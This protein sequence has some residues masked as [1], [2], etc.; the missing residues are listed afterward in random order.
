MFI[1]NLLTLAVSLGFVT[2]T[3]AYAEIRRDIAIEEIPANVSNRVQLELNVADGRD[4]VRIGDSIAFCFSANSLGYISLW[5]VGT[6]GKV[7]KLFPYPN[8]ATVRAVKPGQRECVGNQRY[9][10]IGP[11]GTENVVLLWTQHP[12]AQ[13]EAAGFND[14][15]TFAER[16]AR[17]T[18]DIVNVG[19]GND[20]F[21]AWST[22]NVAFEILDE[23]GQSDDGADTTTDINGIIQT[24]VNFN[25]V[26]VIA[27]GS[28]VGELK[29][30]N[31]DARRF[32]QIAKASFNIPNANIRVV[33]N[34]KRA[35]FES[36]F[37]WVG[38]KASKNDLVLFYYSGHG[39]SIPDDNGDEHDGRDEAIVPYDLADSANW[40]DATR[41]IRDDQ[42]KVW[43]NDISA[44]AVISFFDSC[45]SGGMYK[46]HSQ[47]GLLNGRPKFFSGGKIA[48]KLPQY[49]GKS[50]N[51]DFTRETSIVNDLENAPHSQ[52]KYAMIA[53]S[54][55]AQYAIEV[56]GQG[57]MFT[58]GL[59]DTLKKHSNSRS[60]A[61]MFEPLTRNVMRMSGGRQQ[62]STTD[63]DDLLKDL[64]F[65]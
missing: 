31:D 65:Q 6:S 14:T 55:E 41:Y 37:A 19:A 45:F 20:A 9:K 40:D 15:K 11:T 51:K 25:N 3:V 63:P 62:P 64:K 34:A 56:P 57:G 5:D 29:L 38:N 46:N 24:N 61:E 43:V 48:G 1:K 21:E 33:E 47:L 59:Y 27:F 17:K 36:T 58:L 12:E 54:Q 13:I 22:A 35:D 2:T 30:T 16:L 4:S 23:H 53:A 8:D 44:A 7:K 18:K 42:L 32:A 50:F 60:W 28:N 10:V 49:R 26:F 52:T 39:T